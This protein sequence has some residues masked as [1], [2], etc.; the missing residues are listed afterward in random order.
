MSYKSVPQECPTR[1]SRKS[2]SQECEQMPCAVDDT[3][4]TV[5]PLSSGFLAQR[6]GSGPSCGDSRLRALIW[7]RHASAGT[8]ITRSGRSIANSF[9]RGFKT[10]VQFSFASLSM[11]A[12]IQTAL[13]RPSV[14]S[15]SCFASDGGVEGSADAIARQSLAGASWTPIG[16]FSDSV[17]TVS[18]FT[19][20][21]Y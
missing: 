4:R 16:P 18:S 12:C 14:L 19:A 3:K 11:Y 17:R 7:G 10:Q 1:V 8:C 2:A 9:S 15:L 20:Q 6:C 21:V 5:A 13:P